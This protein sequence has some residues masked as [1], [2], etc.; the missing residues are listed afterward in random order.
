MAVQVVLLRSKSNELATK[1]LTDRELQI[2]SLLA[3]GNNYDQIAAKLRD[4]L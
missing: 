1:N 4:Q 3:R 2:L